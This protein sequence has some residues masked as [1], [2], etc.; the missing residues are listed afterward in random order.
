MPDVGELIGKGAYKKLISGTAIPSLYKIDFTRDTNA[1]I[2]VVGEGNDYIAD[3]YSIVV[4]HGGSRAL[5]IT[6]NSGP[7]KIKMYRDND[8][9]YYVYI[10]GWGY[11]MAYFDN[12]V[13]SNNTISTTMVDIDV[14]TLTQVGI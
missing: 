12:R 7:L 13:P 8:Y 6:H 5:C 1:V 3:D 11:A 2:K 10:Q 14:S 9:N 4:Q